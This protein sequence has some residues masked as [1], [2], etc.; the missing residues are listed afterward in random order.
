MLNTNNPDV[1]F[2]LVRGF[3][4][5]FT[6]EDKELLYLVSAWNRKFILRN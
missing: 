4:F 2:S 1:N 6:V 5:R 3:C